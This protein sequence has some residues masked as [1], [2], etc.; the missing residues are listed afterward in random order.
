MS[1]PRALQRPNAS[2]VADRKRSP[3][4]TQHLLWPLAILRADYSRI[5]EV[6]GLDAY[7]FVRFLRMAARIFLP[8]WVL[9]WIVLLP[10]NSIN[11]EVP[12]RHGLDKLSFGNVAQNKQDRYAA[13]LIMAY[14]LTFWVWWNVKHEMANFINTR[15]RWLISPE[16]SKSAQAS[17]VLIRGVPQRYL[18]ERALKKLYDCLPGGVAKVWLNRDLKDMPDLY[19]RRLEACSRLESA[20]TSL[21]N[22]AAKRRNKKLKAEAK[23]QKKG[24]K[25]P[26]GDDRLL[27]D[28]SI[29]DTERNVSVVEQL[30]PKAKRPTHRLPV[31]FLPFSL[32]L[33]G[34][35]VD[36]IE[37]AR[38]QIV[39]TSVALR[40][41]RIVLA[42]DVAKSSDNS[43][44]PGLP[45][46][47]TNHPDDLKPGAE[48]S[49]QTYPPL[50]SA[51]ILFNRQIAAHLAAQA[52]P[53]HSPYR[54][55][56]RQL[57]VA[58]EDVIWANLN[59]NPYEARI[60]IA[61]S[62]GLTLGLIILWA[63]PVAFVGAISNIHALCTTYSWLAWLCKLPGP[64]V[65]IIS[66]ILPPV[67]L[68]V[69]MMLLPIVL[70]LLSRLE[71][72]ATR[73]GIELSL[74]TRFFLFQVLVS[75]LI[76]S[77]VYALADFAN[78]THSLSLLLRPVS[79][80]LS[81][82]S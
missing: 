50:N 64:V 4:L 53:H 20:E 45:A 30:V 57:G 13:H 66:G 24:K 69:L 18:T 25:S 22:T 36:S 33:I 8:V 40:E 77:C 26:N 78:S 31:G 42:I 7:F 32:P 55:A 58:P 82:V 65:G 35:E 79:S 1:P 39:E 63:F 6:N 17:T 51:F 15:Q 71:G 2:D 67:L 81:Q 12:D 60:R 46:P 73:T 10:V 74:M 68:A 54:I 49:D 27:T 70:R 80:R 5:K 19:E 14:L 52:L 44:H 9:T 56:D 23:A 34:K 76:F 21:M 28:P 16:Y 41:R 38:A 37:W 75:R 62:W 48:V 72:T 11:T 59:L 43:E 29:T 61:I 47:E 3:P